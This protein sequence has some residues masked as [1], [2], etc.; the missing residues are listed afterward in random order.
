MEVPQLPIEIIGEI[1][2][3]FA[4]SSYMWC[5]SKKTHKYWFERFLDLSK[6]TLSDVE[7]HTI[8]KIEFV[9]IPLCIMEQE[10]AFIDLLPKLKPISVILPYHHLGKIETTRLKYLYFRGHPVQDQIFDKYRGINLFDYT[11]VP[12]NN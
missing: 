1:I 4:F 6:A 2:S 7:N 9:N 8:Q 3:Y 5:F 12:T 11:Y 10:K